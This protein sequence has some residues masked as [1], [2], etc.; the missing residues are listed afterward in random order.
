MEEDKI[1]LGR[2][3]ALASESITKGGGP[4]G[5]VI[6]KDNKLLSEAFNTVFLSSDPT[7]HAEVAAIRKAAAALGT[8]NLSGCT[9]YTSCEPCPM[10][11]G[12]I[13]WAGI[14]KVVY[15][16]NRKDAEAAGFSDN[17]IYEEIS[18]NPSERSIEFVKLENA[19]SSEV[20]KRWIEME[21]KNPY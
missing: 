19:G 21:N 18:H 17:F 11:L 14:S 16:G 9:L 2:A 3:V 7:A 5:A 15:A 20:F 8:F 13:Y 4:F 6:V 1:F 10:C 12:A